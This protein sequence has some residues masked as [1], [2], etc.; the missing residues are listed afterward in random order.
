MNKA[1]INAMRQ[2]AKAKNFVVITE[3]EAILSILNAN[4][5][6][7]TDVQQFANQRATIEGFIDKLQ[8]VNKQYQ[9]IAVNK[10]G[11]KPRRNPNAKIKRI[12]VKK[13]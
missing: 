3:K 1:K 2:L 11:L 12:P 6:K 9:V 13:G 8:R 4:P 5:K 10:F 7:F